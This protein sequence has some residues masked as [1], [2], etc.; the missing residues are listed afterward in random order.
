[1]QITLYQRTYPVKDAPVAVSLVPHTGNQRHTFT[2]GD[3]VYEAKCTELQVVIPD[4]AKIDP[5]KNLVIWDGDKGR[6]YSTAREVFD[7]ARAGAS[8]FRMAK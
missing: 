2:V 8:G 3:T 6:V 1:M 7:L 5:V 4:D